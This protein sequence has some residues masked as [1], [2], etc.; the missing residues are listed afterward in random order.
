MIEI[1]VHNVFTDLQVTI[2]KEC[3]TLKFLRKMCSF[4]VKWDFILETKEKDKEID[5][6]I[7]IH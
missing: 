7:P 6:I 1:N 2:K 4:S 3:D 5:R